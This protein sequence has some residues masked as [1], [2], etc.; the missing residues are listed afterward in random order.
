[1]TKEKIPFSWHEMSITLAVGAVGLAAFY[2]FRVST[3]SCK[4]RQGKS[5]NTQKKRS[6]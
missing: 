4:I 2:I 1:M 5:V 6:S 3:F